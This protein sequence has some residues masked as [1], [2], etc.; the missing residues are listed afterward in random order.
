MPAL[1]QHPQIPMLTWEIISVSTVLIPYHD[2]AVSDLLSLAHQ[3]SNNPGEL[4][5]QYRWSLQHL[6]CQQQLSL[7]LDSLEYNLKSLKDRDL[8]AVAPGNL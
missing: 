6:K 5:H 2:Y 3:S 4:P 7:L 8:I 1:L